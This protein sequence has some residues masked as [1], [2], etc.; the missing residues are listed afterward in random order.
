M[1]ILK[2]LNK[3][4]FKAN[5]EL[6]KTPIKYSLSEVKVND[7][8]PVN[9][10][11]LISVWGK[12]NRT[13][14]YIVP[15]EN[16]P[17]VILFEKLIKN[18]YAV[19][20]FITGK[21]LRVNFLESGKKQTMN[22]EAITI[23]LGSMYDY[24]IPFHMRLDVLTALGIHEAFHVKYTLP[25]LETLLI[26]RGLTKNKISKFGLGKT[27]K[28]PD[29]N[30]I[31]ELFKNNFHQILF[32]IVEDKR[33]EKSGLNNYPGYVFYL[34]ELRKYAAWNL[35]NLFYSPEYTNK[36]KGEDG[37]YNALM[38]YILFKTLIPELLP[39]LDEFA[40]KTTLYTDLKKKV[41]DILSSDTISVSNSI[42]QAEELMKLFPSDQQDR[43]SKEMGGQ[44]QGEGGENGENNVA[45]NNP[46]GAAIASE[47]PVD[48]KSTEIDKNTLNSIEQLESQIGDEDATEKK[49]IDMDKMHS[50][51]SNL[52][53][54]EIIP[55]PNSQF[56]KNIFD[57]A[58]E[59]AR[60]INKNL[61][62]LNSRF[63]RAIEAYEMRQGELDQDA[64][65][66]INF[67]KDI[68]F[69]EEEI[70]TWNLDFGILIDESGSMGGRKITEAQI[71]ALGM[72][73]A[74]KDQKHVNLFVYG[75]TANHRA[76]NGA[77]ITMYRYF[78]PYVKKAQDINTMFSIRARSNNADGY[79]IE[80]MGNIMS[81]SKA[82][83]KILVVCSDGQPAAYG[84]DGVAAM[85]HV[86]SVVK[87]LEQQG[88]YVIQVALDSFYS[89]RMFTH[90]IPYDG[91]TLGAN[92]KKILN[93]K[94]TQISNL[95]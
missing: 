38:K 20:K 62:F 70:P 63:S 65:A 57:K 27:I 22:G 24:R 58:N 30:K 76:G 73:L 64:I 95:I 66:T 47:T 8:Y 90:Y 55:A 13:S 59:I 82:K 93:K 17:D 86:A 75:H 50:K 29:H 16:I 41:D 89:D 61:A 5:E 85:N 48:G 78:D 7:F 45:G 77:P 92:L 14:K 69:E 3:K 53:E 87:K 79:A 42:N 56:D 28:V 18:L 32:N 49:R 84:Y 81:K 44:G 15:D 72:A 33:I 91:K 68:F 31:C 23:S 35:I 9:K 39:V 52:N 46:G 4:L 34:D 54:I 37:V 43:L 10:E 83:Q 12:D 51:H 94:L 60:S 11:E 88:V 19:T 80:E 36:F 25:Q 67:N 1:G 6:K 21:A 26:N 74:L 2:D 71:A 40:P